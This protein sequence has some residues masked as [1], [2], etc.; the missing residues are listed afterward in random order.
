MGL[1]GGGE[2]R[3]IAMDTRLIPGESLNGYLGRLAGRLV[4]SKPALLRLMGVHLPRGV[5]A[6][7]HQLHF[8]MDRDRLAAISQAT[9]ISEDRLLGRQLAR[10]KHT[11]FGGSQW[12]LDWTMAGWTRLSPVAYFCPDCAAAG[13]TM[14]YWSVSTAFMC[15]RHGTLLESPL[16]A[17]DAA[18][19]DERSLRRCDRRVS[20]PACGELLAVQQRLRGWMEASDPET[21]K[22]L[23]E[24]PDAMMFVLGLAPA[25][26]GD[27]PEVAAGFDRCV[28][29]REARY[30]KYVSGDEVLSRRDLWPFRSLLVEA[31]S[32]IIAAVMSMVMRLLAPDDGV[33]GVGEFVDLVNQGPD[34]ELRWQ[35]QYDDYGIVPPASLVDAFDDAIVSSVGKVTRYHRGER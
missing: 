28:K 22:K 16:G 8:E 10:Y 24:V 21:L 7:R 25:W 12:L 35:R 5:I 9:H 3:R 4:M 13:V 2:F 17:V 27:H 29:W 31:D 33:D 30:L 19:D 15:E 34:P 14:L 6:S 32:T 26:R 1:S 20:L 23:W 11:W 18:E